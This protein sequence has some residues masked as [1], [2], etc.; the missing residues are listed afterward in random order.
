MGSSRPRRWW[1]VL[2]AYGIDEVH[3]S[4]TRRCLD[5]VEPYAL[6]QHLPVVPEPHV[7]ERG[8]RHK[9]DAAGR[10]MSRLLESGGRV[11]LCSHR[12]VLPALLTA[13]VGAEDAAALIGTGLPPSAMVVIHHVRGR[14]LATER[15]DP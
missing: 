6:A 15:H 5:T 7:S 4:G 9:P 1:T 12:P 10:R 8:H 14:V 13:A 2:A 11:V 3:S